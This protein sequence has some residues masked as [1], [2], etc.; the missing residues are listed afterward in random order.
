[1]KRATK[2]EVRAT[3]WLIEGRVPKGKIVIVSG[4]PG[5][6]KS[7]FTA[8]LAA[9]VTQRAPVIFSNQEDD[10]AEDI[11][12]RLSFAGARLN[13]VFFPDEHDFPAGYPVIPRDLERLERKIKQI[14][15]ALVVFDAAVQ[16]IGANVY[17]NQDVR[18]ALTPLH[19]MLARTGCTAVFV[20]HLKK[21]ASR[22][23][24]VLEAFAG[25]GSGLIAQSR[26]VYAFGTNPEEPDERLLAPAKV[27]NGQ[28]KTSMAFMLEVDDYVLT[29]KSQFHTTGKLIVPIARLV[30][31]QGDCTVSAKQ[32]VSYTGGENGRGGN[33]TTLAVC[34]EWLTGLLM[35]GPKNVQEVKTEAGKGGF[36]WATVRRAAD[37]VKVVKLTAKKAGFGS[38]TSSSW[39]LPKEHPALKAAERALAARKAA[40]TGRP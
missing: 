20:D 6:G 32:V 33:P 38:G 8:W 30:L 40:K 17:A 29:S 27:N 37:E 39:Q 13:R 24:H 11:V 1:V 16:H 10:E 9:Q 12:P 19:R 14:G 2:V 36:S 35:F 5:E 34:A 25:G 26:W 4:R 3:E 31:T 18:R 23:G 21:N 28:A 7:L 22:S 15:A